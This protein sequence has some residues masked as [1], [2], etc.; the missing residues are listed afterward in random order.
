MPAS[1]SRRSIRIVLAAALDV[2]ILVAMAAPFEWLFV[3]SN[4]LRVAAGAIGGV[5]AARAS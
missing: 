2:S 1:N 3:V 4:S 5:V